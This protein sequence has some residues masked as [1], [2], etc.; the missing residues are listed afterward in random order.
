M[1][2]ELRRLL[3]IYLVLFLCAS[4]VN[5]C[6]ICAFSFSHHDIIVLMLLCVSSKASIRYL[7][8]NYTPE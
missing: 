4:S 1:S 6:P 7:T 8:K 2:T 5:I 3:S